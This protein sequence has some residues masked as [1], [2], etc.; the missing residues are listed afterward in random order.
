MPSVEEYTAGGENAVAQATAYDSVDASSSHREGTIA[1]TES[2]LVFSRHK[3][4]ADISLRSVNSIEYKEP[5]YPWRFLNW[6]VPEMSLA[7]LIW[8]IGPEF[9]SDQGFIDLMTFIIG[10]VGVGT[11]LAG[12]LYMRHVLRVHTP[13]KT[14]EF[15]SSN[16]SLSQIAHAVRANEP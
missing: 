10:A 9:I 6:A 7:F 5:T 3:Y 11:L 13:S 12:F 15:A 2:R 4:I 8:V 16:G 1:C 14:Y